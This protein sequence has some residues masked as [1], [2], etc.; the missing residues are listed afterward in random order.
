MF[1]KK[2]TIA[3]LIFLSAAMSA[4]AHEFWLEPEVY[5]SS[6]SELLTGNL[7]N[8]QFF[9]G[10]N[11]AYVE[12][13]AELF[14]I[15]G[16]NGVEDVKGRNGDRPAFKAKVDGDG[17][18]SV[19]YQGKFD[20]ITFTDPAKIKQYVDYE[21]FNGVLERH[22]KRGLPN[23]RFYEQYARCAKALFQVG[24]A[25]ADGNPDSL[26]GMKFELV[27]EKN[28]YTLSDTDALPVRL[29][30]EGKPM[31]DTQIR[32]F[33]INE[34]LTTIEIRT[35]ADGRAIFPLQGGGKYMMNA[36][37][38]FEGDDDPQTETAEWISYWASLSFGISNTDEVLQTRAQKN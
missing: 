32:M 21:G 31:A 1:G 19:S 33:Q 16:P 15:T 5:V 26:T 18:Y 20:K 4:K 11:F 9:K 13:Q 38:I 37:H 10:S 2:I 22:N 3:S 17:L 35:D 6:A 12:S 24:T 30:W 28:P 14:T 8:G 29:Y 25:N 23:D 27:A 34:E 7:K 36:V